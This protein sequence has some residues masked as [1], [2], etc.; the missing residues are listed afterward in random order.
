[1]NRGLYG[2][3]KKKNIKAGFIARGGNP[4]LLGNRVQGGLRG[5]YVVGKARYSEIVA[6]P[7]LFLPP[8]KPPFPL[9]YVKKILSAQTGSCMD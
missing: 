9:D 5:T 8:L 4:D 3:G 2:G 1:M 7:Y 6:R